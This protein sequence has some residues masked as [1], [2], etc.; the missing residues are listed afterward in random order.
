MMYITYLISSFFGEIMLKVALKAP[1]ILIGILLAAQIVMVICNK[2][3]DFREW[4]AVALDLRLVFTLRFFFF[5][6]H[7]I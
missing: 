5:E 6:N 3:L 2:Y 4:L 7:V 1:S